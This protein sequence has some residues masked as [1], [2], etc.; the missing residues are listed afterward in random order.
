MTSQNFSLFSWFAYMR[1]ND[2]VPFS[3]VMNM[4]SLRDVS[5][6][7]IISAATNRCF[8]CTRYFS[9]FS[10]EMSAAE[11]VFRLVASDI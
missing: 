7:P 8:S 11:F 6:W 4:T 2:C 3:M 1:K 5:K 10:H 9:I